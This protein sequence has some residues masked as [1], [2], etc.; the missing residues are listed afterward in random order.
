VPERRGR[1]EVA[2]DD[3][4]SGAD[5]VRDGRHDAR[6]LVQSVRPAAPLAHVAGLVEPHD[7]E[8]EHAHALDARERDD[9][10]RGAV[11]CR[12][13]KRLPDVL[14][15]RTRARDG[16]AGAVRE[17]AA[18]DDR[19]AAVDELAL[20]VELVRERRR[21][22]LVHGMLH[23][24]HVRVLRDDV[25]HLRLDRL[26]RIGLP[27][28]DADRR[29]DRQRVVRAVL[30]ATDPVRLRAR[31]RRGAN[32][33][34]HRHRAHRD[35]R[36]EEGGGDQPPMEHEDGERVD[37]HREKDRLADQEEGGEEAPLAD[38]TE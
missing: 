14:F 6:P 19:H 30:H 15:G 2:H 8:R 29:V 11:A 23:H 24:D 20:P 18:H 16:A 34:T 37:G 1:F 33:P 32:G 36:D 13:Q 31:R 28:Q 9:Q 5:G 35:T 38:P 25:P 7:D 27:H 22:F 12:G 10:L 4:P 17:H 3:Q 26:S 21:D